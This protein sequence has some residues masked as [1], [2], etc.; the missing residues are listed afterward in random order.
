MITY[1]SYLSREVSIPQ[2]AF[3][4]VGA[5]TMV[6]LLAG[7]AIFPLVFAQGLPPD[8]GPGLVFRTLPVAFGELPGGQLFASVFFFLLIAAAITSCIGIFAPIIAWTEERLRV[9][10]ARAALIAGAALWL[11]GFASV[12]SFNVL[13]DMHPLAFLPGFAEKTLFDAI[14]FI[15]ANILLPVGAFVTA[16]FIGWRVSGDVMR[17]EMGLGENAFRLWQVLMRFV[18]PVAVAVIFVTG[19]G[20]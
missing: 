10:H 12:L 9:S 8:T 4:V 16:I 11:L 2:N 14:D 18:V 17:E 15:M 19:I 6:A 1:G 7:F 5:D 20:G 3:I 13:A